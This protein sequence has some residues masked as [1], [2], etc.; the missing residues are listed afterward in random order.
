VIVAIDGPAGSGKS[1]TAREVARRLGFLHIDSGAF[2]RALTA[3]LLA[4]GVPEEQWEG[5]EE[6]DLERFDIRGVRREDGL[7]VT[8]GGEPASDELRSDE[9]NRHV[10]HVARIPAIRNWLRQRLQDLAAREDVVADG[11]DMGTVVFP[12]ADLKIFLVADPEV[13]AR[14]RLLERGT[15]DPD[16]DTLLAEVRRLMERDRMDSER[17]VAPLRRADDAVRVDTTA[18]TFHEQIEAILELARARKTNY[19]LRTTNYEDRAQGREDQ[20]VER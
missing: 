12:D 8:I 3:A 16:R 2:Y 15:D 19:E 17:E 20:A 6:T 5:L 11:R 18:L 9:V 1:T 14:R 7:A 10:S 4:E 13:R